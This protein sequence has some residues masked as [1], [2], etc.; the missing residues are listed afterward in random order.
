MYRSRTR[1]SV[2]SALAVCLGVTGCALGSGA[3]TTEE[4][5]TKITLTSQPNE[6]G[7]A[8]WLAGELGYYEENGLEV[9]IQYASSG[10]AA[11]AAGSAGDWQAGW[12]GG[13]P[14]L[15][16]WDKFE[17][18][19]VGTQL[20]EDSN[21]ILFVHADALEDQSP[22]EVLAN[23]P[24][25]TVANSTSSQ[26]LYAC[27]DHLGVAESEMDVVPLDPPGIVQALESGRVVAGTGFSPPNWPLVTS[28][29]YV[30]VCDGEQAGT[31]IVDPWI[32][33]KSFWEE[34]PEAA[35][36]F[37]DASYRAADYLNENPDEAIE[38]LLT[39]Y[40]EVGIEG[41]RDQAAYAISVREWLT[42]DQALESAEDGTTEDAM[43][44]TS[45]FFLD[46]GV[47]LTSPDVPGMVSRGHEVLQA[48]AEYRA[49]HRS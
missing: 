29:D 20:R 31:A 30:N 8:Q 13:P 1:L 44:G 18:I 25:A 2:Y 22:A 3:A 40:D 28:D 5:T 48:A 37:V 35:A 41:D 47:Y 6:T 14:A 9:D 33:T 11:L 12:T 16:G 21:L 7:F 10:P 23:E 17:L 19:S 32:V 43:Q 36:A 4:G 39:F 42:L 27:A 38:H 24:V 15:T 49:R 45:D 34:E 26:M 46:Q